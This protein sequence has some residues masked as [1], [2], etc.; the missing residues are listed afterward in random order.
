MKTQP[1]ILASLL[2]VS[3]MMLSSCSL[4]SPVKGENK[5]TYVLNTVPSSVPEK[6]TRSITILVTLPE[7]RPTYNTTQMAYTIRPYQVAYFTQNQWAE[8]PPQMLQPLIVRTLQ[9]T[10]L[11]H[12]VVTPPFMGRYEYTLSTDIAML[13]QDFTK[14][15]ARLD[16]K[17]QAQLIK[18]ST[19]QVV[20]TKQFSVSEPIR[21]KSPYSGVAAANRATAKI[22]K[23]IAE[24]TVSKI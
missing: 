4:L 21:Y 16:L 19:N 1:I 2:S 17:V 15:P 23:E 18:S 5:E 13:Q 24:F 10:H 9:K 12:A 11:F 3:A 7:A 8:T 6:K 20:G 22:L 14:V